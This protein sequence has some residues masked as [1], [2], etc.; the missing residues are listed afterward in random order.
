MSIIFQIIVAIL[1]CMSSVSLNSKHTQKL[2]F[3][4]VL[5]GTQLK[6]FLFPSNQSHIKLSVRA[7]ILHFGFQRHFK[8]GWEK[9]EKVWIQDH[10]QDLDERL[11]MLLTALQ[12]T[13]LIHSRL[14]VW[15]VHSFESYRISCKDGAFTYKCNW[16]VQQSVY[17]KRY[18]S[19]I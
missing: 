9:E 10:K 17:I 5:S 6:I 18:F 3:H 19:D 2:A 12:V 4:P 13:W 1:A 8:C 7:I 15:S 16:T 11:R 14:T